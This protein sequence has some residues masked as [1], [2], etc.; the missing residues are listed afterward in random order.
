MVRERQT[1]HLEQWLSMAEKSQQADFQAFALGLRRDQQAVANALKLEWSNGPT[2]GAIT[3]L[4]LIKRT[5]YG[6]ASFETL[7]RRVLLAA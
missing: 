6:R 1:D 7:R 4:K 2:E 5:G 3:R